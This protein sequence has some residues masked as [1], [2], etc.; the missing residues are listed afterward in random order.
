MPPGSAPIRLFA[1]AAALSFSAEPG[2]VLRARADVVRFAHWL[3]E[4][5][6]PSDTDAAVAD[7]LVRGAGR[8]Q[9]LVAIAQ[10]VGCASMKSVSLGTRGT[11]LVLVPS[12]LKNHPECVRPNLAV[13][14]FAVPAPLPTAVT[15]NGRQPNTAWR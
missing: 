10:N 15:L 6:R 7:A 8:A 4:R 11:N 5:P 3:R 14:V 2:V 13:A 1:D 9:T 12:G